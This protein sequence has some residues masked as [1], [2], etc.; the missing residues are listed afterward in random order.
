LHHLL[1]GIIPILCLLL[2]ASLGLA[3][4]QELP[5]CG[6]RETAV[7]GELYT[8][9]SRWCVEEVLYEPQLEPLS[10]TALAV[11]PDGTL[12][13]TL[14]LRGEVARIHDS[15]GDGLPDTLSTYVSGLDMPNALD[16][17]AG[18]LYV[19]GGSAVLRIDANGTV[20]SIADDLP[21]GGGFPLSALSIGADERLYVALGAPCSDCAT[22]ET[23][24][25]AIWRMQ[26]DGSEREVIATGLRDPAT[27]AWFR[28]ALWTVDS[29]PAVPPSSALD[30]LNRVEVGA[31]YGFPDCLGRDT[32]RRAGGC[33]GNSAPS[34]LLGSGSNPGGLAAYPYAT[35]PDTAGTLLLLL[36]GQPH[37]V[38]IVGYKLLMLHF[39]DADTIQRVTVLLP[40]RPSSMRPATIPVR[41]E[42]LF[43]EHYIYIN[44]LGFGIYP[45]QPLALAVSPEGWIYISI[46]G[47]RIIALRPRHNS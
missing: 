47:G 11:A 8:D 42:G 33:G 32:A 45:Q 46:T 17:Y 16:Y 4:A 5:Y 31:W 13:A 25:A 2:V 15:T 6:E 12:Y 40:Y 14:P 18:A 27:L 34:L 1:P 37:V 23:G 24:R 44:E 43:F 21:S 3:Q 28:G 20:D 41:A 26:L 7:H 39:D 30:E 38:D 19:G 36:R 10:F 29:A 9:D 22:G 35:F